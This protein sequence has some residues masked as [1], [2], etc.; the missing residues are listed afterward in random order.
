MASYPCS[1]SSSATSSGRT[2]TAV[3]S[4][5]LTYPSKLQFQR[6]RSARVDSADKRLRMW[7]KMIRPW[8]KMRSTSVE[9]AE[10]T[11]IPEHRNS[12]STLTWDWKI[13][14]GHAWK[15]WI[16]GLVF[17]PPKED[18]F[19]LFRVCAEVLCEFIA[20]FSRAW[21]GK[22]WEIIKYV[23]N[24]KLIEDKTLNTSLNWT[25]LALLDEWWRGDIFFFRQSIRL[26]KDGL[27][28]FLCHPNPTWFPG[29]TFEVLQFVAR[30]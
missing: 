7:D 16:H 8:L 9:V 22:H 20:K 4:L 27:N 21:W 26:F 10:K 18:I 24:L 17:I 1:S 13:I 11:S 5:S 15:T 23:W 28:N 29:S 2:V 14:K 19:N 12:F 30:M 25:Y 3:I 6:Q